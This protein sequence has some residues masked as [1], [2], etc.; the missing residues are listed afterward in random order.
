MKMIMSR[1][2]DLLQREIDA[3]Q[4]LH[5]NI[6]LESRCLLT[7][8]LDALHETL[9]AQKKIIAEI[10]EIDRT[11]GEEYKNLALYFKSQGRDAIA[12]FDEMKSLLPLHERR[13]WMAL[14]ERL[15]RQIAKTRDLNLDNL[16]VIN[17]SHDVFGAYLRDLAQLAAVSGGYNAQGE[18]RPAHRSALLDQRS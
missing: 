11:R 8:S 16:R 13:R 12:S 4:R 6:A 5:E 10:N 17:T 1:L 15:K 3:Y 18:F 9:E 14:R 7:R 2:Y